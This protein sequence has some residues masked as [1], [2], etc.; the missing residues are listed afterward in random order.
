MIKSFLKTVKMNQSDIN[1]EIQQM[2]IEIC[3]L[4]NYDIFILENNQYQIS[5]MLIELLKDKFQF[6]NVYYD[7]AVNLLNTV[8]KLIDSSSHV[9]VNFNLF[10]IEKAMIGVFAVLMYLNNE[11]LG[12]DIFEYVDYFYVHLG[13]VSCGFQEKDLLILSKHYMKKMKGK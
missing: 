10:P 8:N 7:N 4:L 9:D 12:E 1:S 5:L 13:V 3:K 2:E 11:M 6:D